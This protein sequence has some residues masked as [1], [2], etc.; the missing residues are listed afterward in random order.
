MQNVHIIDSNN[1][2]LYLYFYYVF[3]DARKL[4]KHGRLS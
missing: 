1:A 3:G 4:E 2:R